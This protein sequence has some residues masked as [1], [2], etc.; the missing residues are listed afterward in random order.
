M[1][2]S[3][4]YIFICLFVPLVLCGFGQEQIITMGTVQDAV[5][6]K[7]LSN[8]SVVFVSLE[9]KLSNGAITND[10]GRF[11]L[12]M[13]RGRFEIHVSHVNY[14][15][16]SRSITL[17]KDSATENFFLQPASINLSTILITAQKKLI[18]QDGEKITL[19]LEGD[20]QSK[21]E[22]TLEILRRM[23]FVGIDGNDQ[24][25]VNGQTSFKI[26]LNGRETSLFAND[27]SAAL[28]GL[29]GNL[30]LKIEV[31]SSPSAKH[32]GEGTGGIINIIT[33]KKLEGFNGSLTLFYNTNNYYSAGVRLSAKV[34]KIGLIG[35]YGYTYNPLRF[36][37][38]NQTISKT[39]AY[40]SQ[41]TLGGT[42]FTQL[43]TPVGNGEFVW[44]P[45]SL[46]VVSIYN[47]ISGGRSTS[48]V[49]QVMSLLLRD[50]LALS[51]S[52][53]LS[54]SEQ[55]FPVVEFGIDYTKKFSK[56]KN[57]EL[58]FRVNRQHDKSN[59]M[60]A[61]QLLNP[62]S[63]RFI[64][65]TSVAENRQYT[66]QADYTHPVAN[67]QKFEFGFKSI[68]RSAFSDFMS[69]AKFGVLEEY[70]LNAGNTDYFN[71]LQTVVGGYSVY[72]FRLFKISFI[73]GARMEHT[74]VKG[75]FAMSSTK[76]AQ[77]YTSVLPNI[78]AS[79]RV[80]ESYTM[81]L[82]YN[83]RLQRP[84]IA[85]LNPFVNNTD[86]FNVSFGNPHLAPQN[87]HQ[88]M[89][90]TRYVKGSTFAGIGVSASYCNDLII[91]FVTLD[92]KTGVLSTTTG[93]RGSETRWGTLINLNTKFKPNWSLSLSSNVYLISTKN[94]FDKQLRNDATGTN[95]NLSTSYSFSPEFSILAY[96]GFSG[97]PSGYQSKQ[98]IN[99]WY[100]AGA[101][102]GLF[103]NRI[104]TSIRFANLLTS[105]NTFTTTM[106][107]PLFTTV[108]HNKLK[109]W[110]SAAL[111]L[112]WN[113][114]KLKENLSRKKGKETDDLIKLDQQ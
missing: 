53:F 41:R 66:F 23:P 43:K 50:S 89:L 76:V 37:V 61:S 64:R 100:G 4:K 79:L 45:D 40:Y 2:N 85:N 1:I 75:N 8:V 104:T 81:L 80:G 19:N 10:S 42:R 106:N 82:S 111:M 110:R 105:T 68:Y 69:F 86:S 70:K 12:L 78:Q 24:I 21:S 15:S 102:Y 90:Q 6:G 46:N 9:S 16:A 31:Y 114:G 49:K 94:K 51:T 63:T 35:Y 113:F 54:Q 103:K 7:P 96:T 84:F 83:K 101:T 17:Q 20:I 18:E 57:R 87:T 62:G 55:K 11:I 95:G 74:S 5:S 109:T 56:N 27:P 60:A 99:G 52:D 112:T 65:N 48:D 44:E 73:I 36:E 28:K 67:N 14:L 91:Q 47:T 108:N 25:R 13:P 88:V 71:Y 30:V 72:H 33:K 107:D 97:Y 59:Q 38:F 29:P 39:D 77:Q 93:N 26:F 92:R 3:L 98:S 58:V 32:D 34:G 22:N